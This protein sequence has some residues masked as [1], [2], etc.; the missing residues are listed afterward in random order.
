MLL[1]PPA[2]IMPQLFIAA[3]EAGAAHQRWKGSGDSRPIHRAQSL[4]RKWAEGGGGGNEN[5]AANA[6]TG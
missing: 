2:P 1:T 3:A 6:G 4:K 5:A